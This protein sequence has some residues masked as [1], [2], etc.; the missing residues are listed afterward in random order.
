MNKITVGPRDNHLPIISFNFSSYM[1]EQFPTLN[2]LIKILARFVFI[3]PHGTP[4]SR[5]SYKSYK[6]KSFPRLFFTKKQW[7]SCDP[8]QGRK[9]WK[10]KFQ[11]LIIVV[12]VVAVVVRSQRIR[13]WV[14]GYNANNWH[15][16]VIIVYIPVIVCIIILPFSQIWIGQL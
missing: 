4:S 2:D 13:L 12:V 6:L 9:I 7:K 8:Q 3:L 5:N 14:L 15:A 11:L 10:M 16:C 1:Q